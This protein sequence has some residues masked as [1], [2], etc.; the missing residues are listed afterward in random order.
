MP[1]DPEIVI[2]K[3]RELLKVPFVVY[4]RTK[5]GVDCLGVVIWVGKEVGGLPEDFHMEPYTYPPKPQLWEQ[6]FPQ[7]FDEC[8]VEPGAVLI[9]RKHPNGSP[10]H[11]YFIGANAQT[12]IGMDEALARL[13]VTETRLNDDIRARIWKC[14]RFK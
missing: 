7:Y 8:D 10:R 14:Y 13:W 2:A 6:Y 3:A 1:I 12:V 11:C 9:V 4:G 5:R